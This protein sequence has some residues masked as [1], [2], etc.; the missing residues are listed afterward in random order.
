MTSQHCL[1]VSKKLAPHTF[2]PCVRV[3]E[4]GDYDNPHI[5]K[6]YKAQAD[7]EMLRYRASNYSDTQH[8]VFTPL[9]T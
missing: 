2:F 4:T 9:T 3:V 8:K 1:G 6:A 7:N 5:Y